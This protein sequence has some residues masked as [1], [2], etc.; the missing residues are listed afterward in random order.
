[1]VPG[2]VNA[3]TSWLGDFSQAPV[4]AGWKSTLRGRSDQLVERLGANDRAFVGEGMKGL[5][6]QSA[7]AGLDMNV[8]Q[9]GRRQPVG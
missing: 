9:G 1:M 7:D 4:A 8:S 2:D 6:R 3:G 5:D